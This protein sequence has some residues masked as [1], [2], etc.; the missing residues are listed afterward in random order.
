MACPYALH[1]PTSAQGAALWAAG[2]ACVSAGMAG[3]ELDI[4][5]TLALAREMGVQGWPAA[6]LLTALRMGI[7]AGAAARR[8]AT[9][10][11]GGPSHG[12]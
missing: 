8:S 9:P 1:A 5:G 3:I 11:A 4:A 7:A 12:G 10:D 6:E 2:T